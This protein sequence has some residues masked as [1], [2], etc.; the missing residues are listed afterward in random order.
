MKEDDLV[1]SVACELLTGAFVHYLRIHRLPV[2]ALVHTE[3]VTCQR[4]LLAESR[5]TYNAISRQICLSHTAHIHSK[6]ALQRPFHK[7]Q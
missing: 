4:P 7:R 1:L 5:P 3:A 2:S 6:I